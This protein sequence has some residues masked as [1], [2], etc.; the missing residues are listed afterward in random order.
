MKLDARTKSKAKQLNSD[1]FARLT[2][3][4]WDP[5][6][7]GKELWP[8]F[9]NSVPDGKIIAVFGSASLET[10]NPDAD[11]NAHHGSI[12]GIDVYRVAEES[13]GVA[14]NKDWYAVYLEQD[15]N[16]AELI[17]VIGPRKDAEHWI[18]IIPERFAFAEP[19]SV[20]SIFPNAEKSPCPPPFSCQL[21]RPQGA[22]ATRI[23]M[24]TTGGISSRQ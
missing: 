6:E 19:S 14:I 16:G 7:L 17:Y 1:E 23:A 15:Q 20:E 18:N 10:R 13:D 21:V 12:G 8:K 4:N 11:G 5:V 22:T 9:L 24:V 3:S 2:R